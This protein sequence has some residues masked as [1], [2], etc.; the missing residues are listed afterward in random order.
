MGHTRLL[1][2]RCNWVTI[3][4]INWMNKCS[5][6]EEK[7]NHLIC[8]N[9]RHESNNLNFIHKIHLKTGI[10]SLDPLCAESMWRTSSFLGVNANQGKV[11][12]KRLQKVIQVQLHAAAKSHKRTESSVNEPLHWVTSS[13]VSH[14]MTTLLGFLARRSTSSMEIWSTLL[15]TCGEHRSGAKAQL[16]QPSW[17]KKKA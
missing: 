13:R 16:L 14:L 3:L 15:Y 12:P 8:I 5:L 10:Q 9:C 6:P 2:F 17:P 1:P 7:K 11:L 4:I